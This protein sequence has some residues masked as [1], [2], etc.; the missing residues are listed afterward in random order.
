M[1]SLD[2]NVL[3]RWLVDDDPAQ[4]EIVKRLMDGAAVREEA[5]FIPSTVLL[6]LEWVLRKNYGYSKLDVLRTL[7]ALLDSR[8]LVFENEAAIERA[9]HLYRMGNA[10]FGE[11]LH[12]GISGA[13]NRGPMWTFDR[14]ASRLSGAELLS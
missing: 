6:E 3:V 12:V 9:L 11:C 14:K 10:D 2:T 8:E 7:N 4:S 1:A 13:A 5:L